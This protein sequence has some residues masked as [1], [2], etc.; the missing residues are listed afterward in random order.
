MNSATRLLRQFAC[1][2]FVALA[3]VG[4]G[5]GGGGSDG[6][7]DSGGSTGGTGSGTGGSDTGST[8]GTAQSTRS[9]VALFLT[10]APAD[11]A[12]FSAVN[13]RIGRVELVAQN[14][15]RVEVRGDSAMTV[16]LMDLTH[17]AIPLSYGEGVPVGTY[18]RIRLVVESAELVFS[19]GGSANP[20][21]PAD[22][23]LTLVPDNC[24]DVSA[25]SVVHVELD[26]DVAKSI[27]KEDGRYRIRPVFYTDVI[28][29]GRPARLLRLEGRIAGF[30]GTDRVL[31]CDSLPI[32]RD[33]Q[34]LPHGACSWVQ[35]TADSGFFDNVFYA[36][37]PRPL[38]ELF[39]ADKLGQRA[40]VVG[41]VRAFGHRYL[42]LDIPAGQLPPPGE[43]KLWYP[44]RPAG[45]QPPPKPCGELIAT[46]PVDTV[47]IDHDGRIV[48]DRRGLVTVAAVAIELGEFAQLDGAV[49]DPEAGDTFT[50][51]VAP[52][53]SYASDV[54]LPVVLQA[55]P[56]GGNGTQIVSKTGVS[57]SAA[58]LL[59]GRGL[60]VDGVLV[61]AAGTTALR[62]ALV[63]ADTAPLATQRLSG[64]VLT[65][66]AFGAT[67]TA[68]TAADNPCGG[69]AGTVGV[70]TNTSTRF[71]TVIVTDDA[72]TTV[73]GGTFAAGQRVDVYGQC[74]NIDQFDA[75][76]VVIID[77]RRSP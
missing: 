23:T 59:V 68:A 34:R 60:S 67:I 13:V 41:V 25:N 66:S 58:D 76:Q 47:V 63:V 52:G 27:Y 6:T 9:S 45:Q 20:E 74:R 61:N 31:L 50:M 46:A 14:G 77:G 65:A 2:L 11:P 17:Q 57:L 42:A 56:V 37:R 5:G 43:C 62:S 38:A 39:S 18:C 28:G 16:N 69:V 15:D 4:C 70:S 55:A 19:A 26:F 8:G 48:L 1:V 3:L 12:L 30:D 53:E 51:D 36:G 49:A 40:T 32:L 35:I 22:G 33:D 72:S 10:D 71:L 24:F 7:V 73:M 75:G 21:L 54:P 44:E 64:T 29:S